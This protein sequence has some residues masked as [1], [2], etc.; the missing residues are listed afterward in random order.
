VTGTIISVVLVIVGLFAWGVWDRRRAVDE[1][2]EARQGEFG[3]RLIKL[4]ALAVVALVAGLVLQALDVPAA[5]IVVVVALVALLLV[6][7][8]APLFA[9]WKRG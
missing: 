6:I 2:L 4:I 7:Y 3:W 8:I 1:E 5:L 9:P